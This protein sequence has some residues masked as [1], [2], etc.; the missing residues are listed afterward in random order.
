MAVEFFE[1]A[2]A[3]AQLDADKPQ[4]MRE[5]VLARTSY[6]RKSGALT[7]EG[8]PFGRKSP[9]SGNSP[10][11]SPLVERKSTQGR[12]TAAVRKSSQGP[13]VV[14][15]RKSSP[16]HPAVADASESAKAAERPVVEEPLAAE[17]PGDV[18]QQTE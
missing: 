11:T 16:S 3:E 18:S 7:D 12:P 5:A 6:V 10:Q 9:S 17:E 4:I 13:P 1:E 15:K 2:A 8:S 14:A